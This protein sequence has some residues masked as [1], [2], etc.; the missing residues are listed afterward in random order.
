MLSQG[1]Y[2]MKA[3]LFLL[4]MCILLECRAAVIIID[5]QPSALEYRGEV[6]YLPQGYVLPETPSLYV[7]MDGINKICFL[8]TESALLFEQVSLI[9]IL[10]NGIKTEWNCF[11]YKTTVFEVRP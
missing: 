7:T 6:Y 1:T 5:G 2:F 9:V 4:L 3:I 10:V 8:N 11:P